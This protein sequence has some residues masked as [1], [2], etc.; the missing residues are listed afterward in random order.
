MND[1]NPA[2][3]ARDIVLISLALEAPLHS[4]SD[5]PS[6]S[7]FKSYAADLWSLWYSLGLTN[8][9]HEWLILHLN[10][11]LELSTT[12]EKWQESKF[13]QHIS[14]YDDATRE[15]IR[16]IS[17]HVILNLFIRVFGYFM[18]K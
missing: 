11:L 5:L 8:K 12:K 4:S 1:I 3:L 18:F 7:A 16:K 17:L 10:N 14:F 9:Q 13:G 2:I 15:T 6:L